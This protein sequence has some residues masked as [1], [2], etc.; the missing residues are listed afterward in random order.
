MEKIV[1]ISSTNRPDS[2][3]FKVCRLYQQILKEKNADSIILDL[4]QLPENVAFGEL[5]GNRTEKYEDLIVRYIRN[6]SNFIFVVPEY[7]GSF[8]GILKVFID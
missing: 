1:I 7:N 5:H 3:T 8:P 2:N 4:T 6:N